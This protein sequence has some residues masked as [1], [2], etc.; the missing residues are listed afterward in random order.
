VLTVQ[1]EYAPP[2]SS[3]AAS[4]G[5][6]NFALN[7]TLTANGDSLTGTYTYRNWLPPS[8]SSAKVCEIE[9]H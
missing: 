3:T 8:A 2:G 4:G 1:A 5:Q 9:Q 7:L 6:L